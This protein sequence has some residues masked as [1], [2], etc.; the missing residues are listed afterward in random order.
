MQAIPEG[1]IIQL[2]CSDATSYLKSML[3]KSRDFWGADVLA[4]AFGRAGACGACRGGTG[5]AGARGEPGRTGR[6][7]K[8]P[9]CLRISVVY[10]NR[11]HFRR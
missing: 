10:L 5:R 7:R 4:R 1:S 3:K 6:A 11:L 2:S 9:Q 8:N